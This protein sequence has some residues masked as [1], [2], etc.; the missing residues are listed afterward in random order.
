MVTVILQDDSGSE[1]ITLENA[2]ADKTI[3]E[4]LEEQAFDMPYSCRAGACMTCAAIVKEGM[5]YIDETLG[6]EKFIDTDDD[7]ILTCVAGLTPESVEAE[8][9][10][11][12]VLE[13]IDFY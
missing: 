9:E 7:Q 5:D 4:Q 10:Y 11:K 3:I 13:M 1:I 12:V 2:N 6:G 8:V